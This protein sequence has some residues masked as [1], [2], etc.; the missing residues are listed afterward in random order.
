MSIRGECSLTASC[1]CLFPSSL[2]LAVNYLVN[3]TGERRISLPSWQ[4]FAFHQGQAAN[5]VAEEQLL[6]TLLIDF[7]PLSSLPVVSFRK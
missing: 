7:F 4:Q 6:R 5:G 1:A 3:A 2:S